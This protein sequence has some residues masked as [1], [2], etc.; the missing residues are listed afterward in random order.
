MWELGVLFKHKISECS[1]QARG[2]ER[3]AAG[4]GSQELPG[5]PPVDMKSPAHVSEAGCRPPAGPG[6]TGG[7]SSA[8][9]HACP[10]LLI[11]GWGGNQNQASFNGHLCSAGR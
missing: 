9:P 11:D 10:G 7:K 1:F 6:A 5:P 4:G 2:D 3:G 8:D